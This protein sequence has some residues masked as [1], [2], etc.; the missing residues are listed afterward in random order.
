MAP[1]MKS[2]GQEKCTFSLSI[3]RF[4]QFIAGGQEATTATT[5]VGGFQWR[6][7][8][9]I[10]QLDDGAFL[11]AYVDC[12]R[13]G[14]TAWATKASV[15]LTL[16]NSK[17]QDVSSYHHFPFFGRAEDEN[18]Y[19]VAQR[20]AKLE[21][22]DI[23]REDSGFLQKDELVLSCKLVVC[24]TPCP[25]LDGM[26]GER[27][28]NHNVTLIVDGREVHTWQELLS[29]HSTHFAE[30]FLRRD[31]LDEDDS[32]Y[33][34]DIEIPAVD[35]FDFCDFY[36]AAFTKMAAVDGKHISLHFSS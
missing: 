3:P 1:S 36:L 30:L 19:Y 8:A 29:A 7:A 2:K 24:T 31:Q 25:I 21:A 27:H 33:G 35:F 9:S 6:F 10:S 15:V 11:G 26:M 23:L 28:W 17:G 12:R 14:R 5:T 13:T 16:A 34:E 18:C 32:E 20:V 22:S 4:T